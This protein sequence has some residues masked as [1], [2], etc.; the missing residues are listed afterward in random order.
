MTINISLVSEE[1]FESKTDV[2]IR[3]S[4]LALLDV[5]EEAGLKLPYGCRSGSC[6]GCRVVVE[7]GASMLEAR[8]PIEEDTLIRCQDPETVRLACRARFAEGAE[9]ELVLRVAPEVK[10]EFEG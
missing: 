10:V 9:G 2:E 6:G 5:A 3:D 4:N 7:Q 8:T 1:V